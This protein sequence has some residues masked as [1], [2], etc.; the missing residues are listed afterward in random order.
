VVKDLTSLNRMQ[1]VYV[2]DDKEVVFSCTANCNEVI[3]WWNDDTYFCTCT[4]LHDRNN[5]NPIPGSEPPVHVEVIPNNCNLTLPESFTSQLTFNSS[6]NVNNATQIG[7][8]ILPEDPVPG[9]N[10]TRVF[11][12]TCTP[13]EPSAREQNS[14]ITLRVAN[15]TGTEKHITK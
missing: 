6:L 13:R 1:S 10:V 8:F 14:N 12:N 9:M 7:C 3:H 11:N 2:C 5:C 4:V 15:C